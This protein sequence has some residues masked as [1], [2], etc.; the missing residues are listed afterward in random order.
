MYESEIDRFVREMRDRNPQIPEQQARNRATWWDHPQDLEVQ[1]ERRAASVSQPAY[2]Y[3]PLPKAPNPPVIQQQ[4]SI[5]P[6]GAPAAA[7]SAGK[8]DSTPSKPA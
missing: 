3:F 5:A 6:T 2:A 8:S 1:Q 4:P 7:Q